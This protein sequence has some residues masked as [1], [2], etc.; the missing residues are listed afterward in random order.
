MRSFLFLVLMCT[1]FTFCK[2][3]P[4]PKNNIQKKSISIDLDTFPMTCSIRSITAVDE[5]NMWFAGSKGQFGYTENGGK[6]WNIDSIQTPVKAN[7]EFRGIAKTKD[8]IFL[9]SVA[10]PALLFKSTDQGKSWRIV[11]QE[12]HEAAFYDAIAFWDDKNGIAMGDPTDECLS[13]IIT[14]DGG[15]NWMKIPCEQLPVTAKGEAAFAASNSNI[16]VFENHVWIVSGGTKARVF[17]SANRGATW[18]VFDTPIVQ[19]GQM[20]GIFTV[21]FYDDKNG[22]IF[23]G[24]WEKKNQNTGNKATTKDGGRTWSLIADGQNPGYRSS[25]QYV[26]NTKGQSIFAVGIP[27]ISFSTNGGEDWK[28]LSH[29]SFYTMS[30][31]PSGKSAWLAGNNKIGQI[32]LSEFEN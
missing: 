8:A 28:K 25:V 32:T 6:T 1:L 24:D 9:L 26:P 4:S 29:S 23:G 5:N 13:I 16:A 31:C 2:Q 19:G 12:N 11:Y 15:E 22:I 18:E 20:T 17:H 14:K 30:V 27:G 21:A 3:T 10:S 7:L